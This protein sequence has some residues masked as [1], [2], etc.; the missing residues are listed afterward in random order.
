MG[1]NQPVEKQYR[2][3]SPVHSSTSSTYMIIYHILHTCTSLV[4]V[5]QG[6]LSVGLEEEEIIQF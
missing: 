4:H 2:F 1:L 6:P 5:L 3:Y